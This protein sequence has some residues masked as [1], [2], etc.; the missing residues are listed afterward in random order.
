MVARLHGQ[1]AVGPTNPIEHAGTVTADRTHS[2][3]AK[4][5]KQSAAARAVYP[6]KRANEKRILKVELV[7][8]S[9]IKWP[10]RELAEQL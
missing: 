1:A 3:K 10:R 7:V 6:I 2:G 5:D 8:Y 9:A 4:L